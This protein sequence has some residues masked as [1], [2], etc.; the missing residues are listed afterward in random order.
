MK[1]LQGRAGSKLVIVDG[2]AGQGRDESGNEGSPVIAARRALDAMEAMRHRFGRSASVKLVAVEKSKHNHDTLCST[3]EPFI[4]P[5][6]GLVNVLHGELSDHIDAIVSAAGPAPAF[7]FLDPYG[8]RGL[9]ATTYSKALRGRYNE[10]FALFADIGATRLHG[11]ITADRADA[12]DEI[13]EILAAPSLFPD[14]DSRRIAEAEAAAARTNEALDLS[15][16]ASREH[17]TR[18]LGGEHWVA[19][20][21]A[22]PA[23]ARA[24]AFLELFREALVKAGAQYVLAVP[25]RND[26]GNRVYSLVHASKSRYAYVTMKEAVCDG[27]RRSDI[28]DGARDRIMADLSVDVAQIA[29]VVSRALVGRQ[30]RWTDDGKRQGIKS[31]LLQRT[32]IFPFQVQELKNFLKI[33]RILRRVEGKEVCVFPELS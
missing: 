19:T 17:L 4:D 7:Y 25:M 5:H 26:A 30:R 8:I 33:G 14:Y 22:T 29:G 10:I 27:L 2:F 6:P 11:L 18:A 9:D 16:P 3:M 21:E 23:D 1:L 15:I 20:L 12:T 28:S 32:A 31:L 24:D 13:E